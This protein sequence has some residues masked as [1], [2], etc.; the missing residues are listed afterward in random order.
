MAARGGNEAGSGQ[1]KW[2]Y[3]K[4]KTSSH[5]INVQDVMYNM[6]TML[7][8]LYCAFENY[9]WESGSKWQM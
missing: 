1:S 6:V 7:I 5:K 4:G 2:T 8:I 3:P 9:Q